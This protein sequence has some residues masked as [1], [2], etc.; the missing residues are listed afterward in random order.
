MNYV[1]A[2]ISSHLKLAEYTERKLFNI[3]ILF[4]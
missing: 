4:L 3:L 2:Y 1:N